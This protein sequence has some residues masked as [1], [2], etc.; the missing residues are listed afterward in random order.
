MKKTMQSLM[1]ILFFAI[2]FCVDSNAQTFQQ[3]QHATSVYDTLSASELDTIVPAKQLLYP[4]EYEWWY[5]ADSLTG[6]T[7]A[8]LYVEIAPYGDNLWYT[9]DSVTINGA[10]PQIGYVRGT[11]YTGG[12]I[13][14]RSAAGAGV[15]TTKVEQYLQTFRKP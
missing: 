11:V 14:M 1:L 9:K 4:Y 8:K 12:G 6:A 13:R 15:Q 10:V 2:S 3:T 7:D 5:R